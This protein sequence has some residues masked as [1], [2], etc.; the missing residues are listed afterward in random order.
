MRRYDVSCEKNLRS[1][2]I[3]N[4]SIM[5]HSTPE[6]MLDDIWILKADEIDK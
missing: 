1:W 2:T 3:F 4:C 6:V 5:Y